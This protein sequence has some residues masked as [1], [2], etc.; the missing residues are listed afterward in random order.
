MK[1]VA[2]TKLIQCMEEFRKFDPEMSL[3]EALVF[4][5][6]AQRRGED[7]PGT[8]VNQ[9]A[10]AIDVSRSTAWRYLARLGEGEFRQNTRK[11]EGIGL[12]RE[13]PDPEFANRRIW[14]VSPRGKRVAA[15]LEEHVE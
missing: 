6:V 4:A 12:L 3:V 5:F 14:T 9:V 8:T 15:A 1:N 11:I 13:E 2:I 7:A 10:E